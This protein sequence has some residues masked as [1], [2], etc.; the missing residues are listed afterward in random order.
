MDKLT[1]TPSN[2]ELYGFFDE[3]VEEINNKSDKGHTHS[4][5]GSASVGGPATSAEKL[6]TSVGDVNHPV[7][8][9]DGKPELCESI[10]IVLRSWT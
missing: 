2:K 10:G 8:F 9:K 1:K 4:Y 6:T 7:Y 3:V 5:A